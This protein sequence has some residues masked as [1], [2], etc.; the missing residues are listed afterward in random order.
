MP[1]RIKR[2]L[3]TFPLPFKLAEMDVACDA[4]D[5]EITTEEEPIGDFMVLAYRRISTTIY[6]PPPTGRVGIGQIIE[7]NPEQLPG[8]GV[9]S[10]AL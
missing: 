4:G 9:H 1:N 2:F 6:I 7:I 8:T 3:H 10:G 5:Y